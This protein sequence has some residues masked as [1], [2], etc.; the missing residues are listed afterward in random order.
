ME[1]IPLLWRSYVVV[2]VVV[3]AVVIVVV[4]VVVVVVVIVVEVVVVV[5]VVPGLLDDWR[6]EGAQ[7]LWIH[8]ILLPPSSLPPPPLLLLPSPPPPHLAAVHHP[9]HSLC[10][11][12]QIPQFYHPIIG[13]G[14]EEQ[15]GVQ[16][17]K[18]DIRYPACNQ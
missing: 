6:G 5:V 11:L 10:L 12:A 8:F 2:V 15:L 9:G 4:V 17:H 3:V 16:R 7:V 18:T 1:K 14:E 13:S